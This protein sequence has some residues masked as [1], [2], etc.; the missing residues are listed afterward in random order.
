VSAQTYKV[1]EVK[2]NPNPWTHSSG[3]KNLDYRCAFEGVNGDVEVTRKE[4]SPAP[5]VGD[6]LFGTL[7]TKTQAGYTYK[8][9]SE[10]QGGGGGG[11]GGA[12][13]NPA[14]RAS[15][16]RQVAAKAGADLLVA[17]MNQGGY[18]P[19]SVGDLAD[20]HAVLMTKIATTIASA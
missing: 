15:I 8:F 7:Q 17:M 20:A 18:K 19:S 10:Q 1:A 2:G 6:E 12:S 9:K 13:R 4:S 11:G 3:S 16:E 14:E 5:Q